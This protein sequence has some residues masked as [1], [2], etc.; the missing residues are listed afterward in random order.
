MIGNQHN[1]QGSFIR[2]LTLCVLDAFEGRIGW[3]NRMSNG[4]N[5]PVNVKF[6][7]SMTGGERY[8]LDLFADDIV[9]SSRHSDLNMDEIPRGHIIFQGCETEPDR[10]E[11]PN[12]WAKLSQEEKGQV[13][14]FLAKIR[15]IPFK[16]KYECVIF[17]ASEIDMGKCIESLM[18][19]MWLYKYIYFEHNFIRQD[20]FIITS[21]SPEYTIEREIKSDTDTQIKIKFDIEVSTY[22]PS[23]PKPNFAKSAGS[24]DKNTWDDAYTN[25]LK[26][27]ND[28][29]DLVAPRRTRW[30]DILH[31]LGESDTPLT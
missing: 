26:E 18:D 2:D 23:Y 9:N 1:S 10:A 24:I 28:E 3:V 14:S 29:V 7:P 31:N 16:A 30:F 20:A 21:P 17:V 27:V 19:M 13:R 8:L 12:V 6:Y 22:Y 11:N 25:N 4:V 15:A 5:I